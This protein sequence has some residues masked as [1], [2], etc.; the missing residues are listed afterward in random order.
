M[1]SPA[2]PR[3][4]LLS[5]TRGARPASSGQIIRPQGEDDRAGLIRFA[6]GR[7]EW[8]AG[9][10]EDHATLLERLEAQRPI[11]RTALYDA[12]AATPRLVDDQVRG[13]KAIVLLTDGVDN[14]SML[15]RLRAT[16]IARRVAVPIYT[17][18][19]VS[20]R[21]KLLARRARDA[22]RVLERFSAETGGTLFVVH[23][24]DDLGVAARRIRDELRFQYAIGF[25]PTEEHRDGSFRRLRLE[26]SNRDLRVRTRSGYYADP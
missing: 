6:D 2:S 18:G 26:T 17:V 20:M 9:F 13:R 3:R 19:F 12:L 14:A 10:D 4:I 15:P 23:D 24:A 1:S 22:L 25:R 16:W 7:V 8:V 5:E 21:E 11:G